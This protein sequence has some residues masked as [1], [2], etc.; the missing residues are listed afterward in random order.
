[1]WNFLKINRLLTKSFT[2]NV[3]E[4]YHYKRK[5]SQVS[6]L[7]SFLPEEAAKEKYAKEYKFMRII[8]FSERVFG[9][10]KIASFVERLYGRIFLTEFRGTFFVGFFPVSFFLKPR[11]KYTGKKPCRNSINENSSKV[12]RNTSPEERWKNY[13]KR[14]QSQSYT[15]IGKVEMTSNTQNSIIRNTRKHLKISKKSWNDI[16][17]SKINHNKHGKRFENIKKQ[18]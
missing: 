1:M 4:R 13:A 14:R 11:R 8:R 16:Q 17:Y 9:V 10:A 18:V 2:Q 7:K 12:R 15:L 6:D 3:K 5:E